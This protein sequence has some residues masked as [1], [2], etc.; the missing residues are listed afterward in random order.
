MKITFQLVDLSKYDDQ[1]NRLLHDIMADVL[2]KESEYRKKH[3][4]PLVLSISDIRY[5]LLKIT[6]VISQ[7]MVDK[8]LKSIDDADSEMFK[9][10]TGINDEYT[11]K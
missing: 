1:V 5:E 4:I 2:N 6:A 8:I 3:D 9:K 10:L 11:K 7:G